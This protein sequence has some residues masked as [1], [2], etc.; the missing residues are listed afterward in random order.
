M[1]EGDILLQKQFGYHKIAKVEAADLPAIASSG[2]FIIRAFNV[3]ENYLYTYLTSETGKEIFDRQLKSIERGATIVSIGLSDLRKIRVPLFDAETMSAFVNIEKAK[4]SELS[5]LNNHLMTYA[6]RLYGNKSETV[7]ETGLEKKVIEDLSAVGW[8][9]DDVKLNSVVIELTGSRPWEA[10][11]ALLDK[12]DLLAIVE[13]RSSIYL[14]NHSWLDNMKAI[15]ESKAAPFLILS[16][17]SYYEIHS[18][19]DGTVHKM[20]SPPTKEVLLSI[21]SGKEAK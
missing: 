19:G 14:M 10:D 3:P 15:I 4:V 11:I 9:S 20:M 6:M 2:L 18:T 13:V 12:G 16:S 21:L 7:A 8:G 1:E 5:I 17:G